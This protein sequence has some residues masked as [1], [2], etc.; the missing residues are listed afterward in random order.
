MHAVG[1]D[2]DFAAESAITRT[3]RLDA[4]S[5]HCNTHVVLMQCYTGQLP[6]R[7]IQA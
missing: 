7:C 6:I 4:S 2:R 3:A 1:V 5:S